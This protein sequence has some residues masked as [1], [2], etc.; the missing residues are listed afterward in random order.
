VGLLASLKDA[1]VNVRLLVLA[2]LWA[3]AVATANS[4][5]PLLVGDPAP[6]L[7]VMEWL[8]G[9]PISEFKLGQVYVVEFWATWCGPC[10]VEMPRL[11]S[12][13]RRYEGKVIV[14][15]VNVR[16]K[17]VSDG[18]VATVKKFVEKQGDKMSYRVAMDDPD[19]NTVFNA[20]LTA[21]GLHGIPMAFIVD[22]EGRIAWV[23]VASHMEGPLADVLAGTVDIA[24]N[25]AAQE[26][27]R[28]DALK[29][30][31]Y[32]DR[33]STV[34]AAFK[35][36]DYLLVVT[37]ADRLA[38]KD[39]INE[40]FAFDAKLIALL[41][42]DESQALAFVQA[43][44][45]DKAFLKRQAQWGGRSGWYW[46]GVGQT[47]AAQDGLTARSYELAASV[48]TKGLDKDPEKPY[49]WMSLAQ[50][51]FHLHDKRGAI[52]AMETAIKKAEAQ[53]IDDSWLASLKSLLVTYKKSEG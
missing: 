37:E 14:V 34:N 51:R 1:R 24:A 32:M 11:S 40:V 49:L 29:S 22:R 33:M 20:W 5:E 17:D 44:S 15:G 52:S 42:I 26:H 4:H 48:L 38:A 31:F 13:A 39:P 6:K 10:I 9:E 47:L 18:S 41:H 36:K 16:E 23:G 2:L 53:H 35:R 45:V 12:L 46:I 27:A 30:K 8:K 21:A 19:R 28:K 25:R 3:G 50:A 7:A 43:K